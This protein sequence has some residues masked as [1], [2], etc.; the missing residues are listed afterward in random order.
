MVA[1]I[2][3]A[4]AATPEATLSSRFG[5]YNPPGKPVDVSMPN[6]N[7]FWHSLEVGNASAA[8]D[9]IKMNL[10]TKVASGDSSLRINQHAAAVPVD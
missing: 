2:G 6:E 4:P 10:P 9:I 8:V 5:V 7:G 1:A 3:S